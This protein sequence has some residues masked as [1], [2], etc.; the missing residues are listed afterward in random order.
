M[1]SK[2]AY[3]TALENA[4]APTTDSEKR[5]LSRE[6]GFN[7]RQVIGELIYAMVTCRP[8]ISFPLIKLSQYSSNPAHAHYIA[9]A[10]I[11]HYLQCTR[12]EGIYFWR[13]Q[14]NPELPPLDRS[15]DT[16]ADT[17]EATMQD[18]GH[19]L[20][21]AVDSNWGGDT[22]HRRSVTGFVAKLAGGAIYYKTR[23]QDTIALSSTKAEFAAA[24]DAGKA[25]LYI[26]TILDQLN[27]PQQDATILHINNNGAL[28]MANQQQP[29][30][31]TR[32]VDIKHFVLQ[33]WVERDLLVLRRITTTD[34]YSDAMTKVTGRTLHYKHFDYIMGQ[35]RPPYATI[36][37]SPQNAI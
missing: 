4:A 30:Q 13:H 27:I 1:K 33:D 3:S 15:F 2:T 17:C 32:H 10:D 20:K 18:D 9:A 16:E 26:R 8:D 24:V 6:M 23:F 35:I 31:R 5:A 19:R 14:H 11:L 7:Y 36:A 22:S 25:I 34:N 28:N 21:A 12:S 37:P 29:T